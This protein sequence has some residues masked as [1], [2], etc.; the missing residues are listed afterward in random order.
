[1]ILYMCVNLIS[2]VE[3]LLALLT[4]L[5]VNSENPTFIVPD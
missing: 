1:M 2:F 3:S 5:E 4:L